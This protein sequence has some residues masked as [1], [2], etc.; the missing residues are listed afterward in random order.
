MKKITLI[1]KIFILNRIPETFAGGYEFGVL[2]DAILTSVVASYIF[3]LFVI[4]LKDQ[5]DK[6]MVRPYIEK[7]A[8]SIVGDCLGILTEISKNSEIQLTLM[9]TKNTI[10][11][12][13]GKINPNS[14][15]PLL[16]SNL[17]RYANWPEFI[18]YRNK[19]SKSSCK[20]LLDHL[21]YLDSKLTSLVADIDDCSLFMQVEMVLSS[22]FNNT[23][24]TFFTSTFYKYMVLSS[25]LN[26]FIESK[27]FSK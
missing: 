4:H 14:Q 24:M 21:P 15:S 9:S 19:R 2:S 20:K 27:E 5:K 12:A 16:F 11:E 13:L 3:Y 7:H 17:N 18:S 8:K 26:V 23:D 22:S 1:I 25:N 10:E 6:E